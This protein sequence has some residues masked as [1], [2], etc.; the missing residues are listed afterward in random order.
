M[1]RI[2]AL[3]VD[4]EDRSIENLSTLLTQHCPEIEIISTSSHIEDAYVKII[5]LK[6]QV[7][8]LDVNMPPFSGFDLLEKFEELPFQVVFVTAFD[9]YAIDAIKISALYYI[10]KP[11]RIKELR[12][13]VEKIVKTTNNLNYID[14]VNYSSF[15]EDK[16]N[17]NKL[18]INTHTG[19]DMVLFDDIYY[20]ESN[21]TYSTFYLK[22]NKKITSSRPIKE[23]EEILPNNQFF[24]CH[25]SYIVNISKVISID[26]K[27]GDMLCLNSNIKIPLST[28]KKELF[29]KVW[30]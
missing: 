2:T 11:I 28:R 4:D 14:K 27:E 18:I 8:F 7:V 19:K 16:N 25:R 3:L 13:S 1:E 23:Y 5:N 21:N 17:P 9:Y 29:L 6:P 22:N 12:T 20:I 26:K 30:K 10:L 15:F 24:R